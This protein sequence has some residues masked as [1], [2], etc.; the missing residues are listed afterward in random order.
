MSLYDLSHLLEDYFQQQLAGNNYKAPAPVSDEDYLSVEHEDKF[1]ESSRRRGNCHSQ[2]RYSNERLFLEDALGFSSNARILMEASSLHRIVHTNAAFCS[3]TAEQEPSQ[4]KE[5][6]AM[7]RVQP[8][9]SFERV[10]Y[11]M[12]ADHS[13]TVYP[14]QDS[15]GNG[16]LRYYLV[17]HTAGVATAATTKKRLATNITDAA[18]TVG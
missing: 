12:F 8:S 6:S 10:V 17:E 16:M 15:D 11:D 14:V 4:N 7:T 1:S 3:L 5:A 9:N 13:V 2:V 18:Q